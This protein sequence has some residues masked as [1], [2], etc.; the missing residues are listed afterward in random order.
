MFAFDN[1][2]PCL[3]KKANKESFDNIPIGLRGNILF[4]NKNLILL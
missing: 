4:Q 1:E 2:Q 3:G